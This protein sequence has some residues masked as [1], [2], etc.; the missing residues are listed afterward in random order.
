MSECAYCKAPVKTGVIFC[1][2]SCELLSNWITLGVSPVKGQISVSEKW[3]KYNLAEL[4]N[5]FN[6][7]ACPI[8]KKFRF[9]I[10][11]LQCS[12]CVHL[13][14]DLPQYVSAVTNSRLN[15]TKRI[16][17]VEIKNSFSLGELCQV[18][19]ELGYT[20]SPLKE[21]T[22]YEKAAKTENRNDLKRIG[23]AGAVAA[24]EMLFSI[25]IYAGLVGELGQIF[26]WLSFV[27]FLPLIFYAAMPF[28]RKAWTSLLVRRVNVDMMIVVALLAGFIF[29]SYSLLVGGD[30]LYFDSTASFIFLILLTRYLLKHHQDK[31]IQKNILTDLFVNDIYEV[32][33]NNTSADNVLKYNKKIYVSFNKILP[34][35]FLKLKANQLVPCDAVLCSEECD[36]DLSFLTGEAYPQKKHRGEAILAG[37]RLLSPTA[38]VESKS[39]ALQSNLAL[40]LS[41]IDLYRDSK[42][43]KNSFQSLTDIISHRLTLVV[44]S[45]AGLFFIL[46]Y[47]HLGFEAFKRCL[48]LITIACPCAVAFGTP[49]A[50]N[51]G[52]R[53]AVQRGFFIKSEVVFEKLNHIK[54][55]IFD[56]TGTLTST[57]LQLI[58]TFPADIAEE[59][60]SIILGLEKSSMHPVAISLKKTW[61]DSAITN[62][63]N[64][65]EIVGDGVEAVYDGHKYQLMKAKTDQG[66]IAI[67]VDFSIDGRRT[68]YLFF[69][70][71][72][73]PEAKDVIS[74]IYKMDYEVMLLSGDK[75]G[76]AIEVA[77]KLGIRPAHVFSEQS[78]ESK[79]LMVQQQAPCLFVGDGLN[80][81]PAL[82]AAYVSFAIKGSF[83]SVLQVSDIY[84]PQKD[85]NSILEIFSLSKKI[86]RTVQTNLLFAI[87]YNSVGGIMALSGLINPFMAAV[88]M[89]ASS[90]LITAHTAWRLK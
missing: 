87:L 65:N 77:K 11:G 54:K 59:H 63:P 66:D 26:K 19:E 78:A 53:K 35:Q 29:S 33:P 31:L 43:A 68:A 70:E 49:L 50:H 58:K 73:V 67:Q 80:D 47:Q 55:I 81:L 89:P 40:S 57:Q 8:Y 60:K 21:I 42:E 46:T 36:V 28:Y 7:S 86:H 2:Q 30:D 64:I 45:V 83:E 18:I 3:Q 79:K 1:C 5:E 84:A 22:D 17:E 61:T 74:K 62:I 52:L 27:I 16:L 41:K 10:E 24:N 82:N 44:F 37:S 90:L 85:L 32:L 34:Q 9:Y 51:F 48:A 13:L 20:P 72:I 4:E 88:L 14:E 15:Y 25:P 23:V 56:K 12:S 6:F 76:R 39:Y 71:T 38:V 69:E 75:R